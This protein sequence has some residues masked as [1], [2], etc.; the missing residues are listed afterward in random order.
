MKYPNIEI[1]TEDKNIFFDENGIF[2]E[3]Y[4]FRES[5]YLY[6][7]INKDT[8]LLVISQNI[9]KV[10]PVVQFLLENK[11]K[12]IIFVIDDIFRISYKGQILPMMEGKVIESDFENT[13][14][15]EI[16]IISNILSHTQIKKFDVF[17]CEII[18]DD[19]KNKIGYD[20][21]YY[22]KFLNTWKKFKS[23]HLDN[24]ENNL[25]FEY[26]VSSLSNRW[27]YHR[28]F[29]TSLYYDN[30]EF[31]YTFCEKP[32]QDD[33][34]DNN[35]LIIKQFPKNVRKRLKNKL[36]NF[37]DTPCVYLDEKY[38]QT[39]T[40]NILDYQVQNNLNVYTHIQNSFV[41]VTNETRFVSPMQYISE[42]SFKPIMCFRPLIMLGPPGNLNILKTWGFKTFN[43]WWDESYDFEKNHHKR[44]SMIVK[45]IDELLIKDKK[46]LCDMLDSMQDVLE[47]NYN[48]FTKFNSEFYKLVSN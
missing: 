41:N 35:S 40:N 7:K 15:L 48:I 13:K 33:M 4:L 20:I 26:K 32:D 21:K 44:F 6:Q 11:I 18:P 23:H 42:K 22:D 2:K 12:E 43:Q 46:E 19:I 34:L 14:L 39:S 24:I 38:E 16:E 31:S 10:N 8:V 5:D 17:H 25:N 45:I 27:D 3:T 47:H 9:K 36:N 28:T 37:L 29:I 30:P 1:I